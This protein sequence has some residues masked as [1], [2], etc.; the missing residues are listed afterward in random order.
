MLMIDAKL[1][2][3]VEDISKKNKKAKKN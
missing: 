1:D 2:L 3:K